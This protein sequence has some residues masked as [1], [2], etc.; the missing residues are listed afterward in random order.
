MNERWN[1]AVNNNSPSWSGTIFSQFA[2]ERICLTILYSDNKLEVQRA[3]DKLFSSYKA[4]IA[5]GAPFTQLSCFEEVVYKI[6]NDEFHQEEDEYNHGEKYPAFIK[7][8]TIAKMQR[9]GHEGPMSFLKWAYER[10]CYYTCE[11]PLKRLDKIIMSFIYNQSSKE[12]KNEALKF[13]L[14]KY[15]SIFKVQK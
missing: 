2:F 8:M 10:T 13:F 6:L 11:F 14:N 1:T 5:A 15:I 9:D 12:E 4:A 3:Y 7:L